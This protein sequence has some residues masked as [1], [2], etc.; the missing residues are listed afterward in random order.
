[1]KLCF[2]RL[3]LALLVIVFAWWNVTWASIALTI[4][5]AIL[6]I[7]ALSGNKCCCHCKEEKKE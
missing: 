7:M 6:V 4:I 5:G 3:I 2:C 1:M